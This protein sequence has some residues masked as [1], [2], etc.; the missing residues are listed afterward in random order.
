MAKTKGVKTCTP[1]NR[2]CGGRCIPPSW[3]CRLKGEGGDSHLRA[4]GKGRDPLSALANFQ[5]GA[6]RLKRGVTTGN[7]S[8]IEGGRKAVIRGVV[9]SSKGDLKEKQELQKKLVAGTV[10]AGSVLAVVGLGVGAHRALSA[11]PAYRRT[12]GARVNEAFSRT[13]DTILNNIPFGVG[14]ERQARQRAAAGAV[15]SLGRRTPGVSTEGGLAQGVA[16]VNTPNYGGATAI[17]RSVAKVKPTS[18]QDFESFRA[19]SITAYYGAR[20]E[21]G[22]IHAQ[23][24]AQDTLLTQYGIQADLGK[25]MDLAARKRIVVDGIKTSLTLEKQRLTANAKARGISLN[26]EEART[27]YVNSLLSNSGLNRMQEDFARRHT[28]ALLRREP[29][30]VASDLYNES[31]EQYDKF[32]T[33]VSEALQQQYTPAG[34]A[35][36]GA[37]PVEYDD[38]IRTARVKHA[39]YL[40]RVMGQRKP[41]GQRTEG[42]AWQSNKRVWGPNTADL[43]ARMYFETNAGNDTRAEFTAPEALV[44]RAWREVKESAPDRLFNYNNIS[45]RAFANPNPRTADKYGQLKRVFGALVPPDDVTMR[46]GASRRGGAERPARRQSDAQRIASMMRQKN[47]DGTPRYATREAAEAALKRMRKDAYERLD[48]TPK[49]ERK[50]KPCGKSFIPRS[51]KCSKPTQARYA[52]PPKP[53]G[54]LLGKAAQ[55]SAV[56]GGLAAVYGA[57]K[58]RK[59]ISVAARKGTMRARTTLRRN[60][61]ELYRRTAVRARAARRV[62]TNVTRTQT[63][64]TVSELSK[65]TI[66]TLSRADVDKGISRL[67]KQFQEPARKL[68]GDAKLS[69]AHLALK[70]KGGRITSVNTKDNFSNWQMK[71]G[72]LLSTGSVDDTL[73]IYNTKPQERIGGART[74]ATQFR[75]DGEFDAKSPS[76]SRNSRKVASTVKKMFKSQ[77]NELPDNSIITAVP[78][79]NDNKGKKRRSIYELV[80]FREAS[81]SDERLFAIKTKGKFTRM[82]D[83]HLEQIR[84]LL[85]PDESAWTSDS[86]TT[87]LTRRL[88]FDFTPKDA[89]QG[90]PC[91]KSFIPRNQKCSKPTTAQYASAPKSGESG[92]MTVAQK[93]GIGAASLTTAGAVAGLV[94]VTANKRKVSA[95]RKNVSKSAMEAEKL[96]IEYERQFRE[97][98]AKRLKKR[99]Q[100]VTDFEASVYNYNDKGQDRGFGAFESDAEW[101]G[102]TKQS[103]GAVVMLSYADARGKGGFNMVKG[104]AFQNIWGERDILPFANNISQP[105]AS[106][107]LDHMQLLGRERVSKRAERLAGPVGARAVKGAF[108]VKDA[109]KRFEFLRKNVDERGFNPDAVRAAAFVVAQRRLTG[110]PVDIMSYSNGGNVATETLA[111]LNDMGYRDVKVINVAGPTF[112]IFNHSDDNMRTWVSEGDEFYKYS[113]G[114][115]YV[116]GNTRM[117]KNKNIPHGL[118]DGIDPNN[119]ETGANWRQNMKD[120]KSYLLDEQLQQEAYQY[121]TVDNKRANELVS[122]VTWRVGEN[123]KFEGD[124]GTLFGSDSAAAKSRFKNLLE[125][126]PRTQ[127]RQQIKAEIETRMLDVWYGGYNPKKVKRAQTA[128]RKELMTYTTPQSGADVQPRRPAPM[129]QRITRLMEQNPGMSREAARRQIQRELRQRRSR[130]D[131]WHPLHVAQRRLAAA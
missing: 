94:A 70:S 45:E 49:A 55:V 21:G 24:A 88:R 113:G 119:R 1:P 101:F 86:L 5:R 128:I 32:F 117:L 75:V 18:Y 106:D 93:V 102:Q 115:A 112:G 33:S 48:F 64:R 65:R 97:Q 83:N 124:L 85:Q 81:S 4:A 69:A 76:A 92:G 105:L 44:T 10:A 9:K 53:E 3:D 34:N 30:S 54:D 67:P 41:V 96:A 77:M 15:T 13:E 129:S 47:S 43:T 39:E 100:D 8:E 59:R 25:S 57:V 110:K 111:I 91:G 103:K 68:V 71:D 73:V 82:N 12:V 61:P 6:A 78:Y 118:R 58:N 16:R 126:Q 127:A 79:A 20:N 19:D 60:N 108:T 52:E 74:Y 109:L 63:D 38:I 87:L 114:K 51:Q 37:L 80:G 7:F 89:R 123:M 56:A 84:E 36:K 107:D 40:D 130:T 29:G 14:K 31:V 116:G 98:A 50:G 95:Y 42:T 46:S 26:S 99:P 66:Q 120:K 62:A 121:L 122:E 28:L 23:L 22:N 125:T 11:S 72:T 131:A 27:T 17:A 2:K 35:R 104:G 90:K